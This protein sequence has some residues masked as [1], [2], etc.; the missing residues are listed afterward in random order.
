M[1]TTASQPLDPAARARE[2]SMALAGLSDL[3]MIGVALT[4]ALWGNSLMMAAETLRGT[5]LWALEMV[6]LVLMRRIHRGQTHQFD[7][8][9]GKLEQF[10]NLVIGLVMGVGGLWV[11]ISAAYRWWNPPEHSTLGMGFAV[12]AGAANVVQNGLALVSLWRAGRDGTS[13][14]LIGQVRTRLAKLV[15]SF[16]VLGALCVGLVAGDTLWGEAAEVLGAGFVS[17]VMLQLTFALWREAL[18]ALLDHTL[19]EARQASIN[20]VLARHFE[21]YEELLTVRSRLSGNTALIEV[22]LGF[23]PARQMGEVQAVVDAICDDVSHLI[24]GALVSV[25]PVASRA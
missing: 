16:I 8:G 20:R 1:A 3:V 10:A 25:I 2:R 9:A 12:F 6:L 19:D 15:S 22:V 4:A 14:I 24:P 7:Y 5:L 23:Q 18:P 11:G 13:L 21:G 17:V